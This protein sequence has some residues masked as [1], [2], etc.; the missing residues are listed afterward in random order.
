MN[1]TSQSRYLSLLIICFLI[2]F[3]FQPVHASETIQLIV[4]KEYHFESSGTST[5]VTIPEIKGIKDV[6]VTKKINQ[7]IQNAVDHYLQ[8]LNEYDQSYTQIKDSS[9]KKWIIDINYQTYLADQ[10]LI[11]FSINTTQ[12]N[13]SSYL[14]KTFLNFDLKAGNLLTVEDF[15][16]KNYQHIIKDEIQRQV[17]EDE[18]INSLSILTKLLKILKLQKNN[19]SI[20]TKINKLLLSLMSSI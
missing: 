11:S 20:S 10:S 6:Q 15:L 5:T 4:K 3:Q 9:A 16:G 19:L 18:K 7:V 17:K 12:I 14:Q 8:P 2:L 1:S 13:A